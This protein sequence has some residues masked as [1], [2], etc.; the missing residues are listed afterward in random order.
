MSAKTTLHVALRVAAA[1]LLTLVLGACSVW[2]T[3][4]KVRSGQ[5]FSPGHEKYDAYFKEVHVLQLTAAGWDEEKRATRR[6]LVDAL[7]LDP[8]VADVSIVQAT[9]ER[10]V[11]IGREVGPARI[12]TKHKNDI[13]VAVAREHRVDAKAKELFRG[14]E[15]TVRA[16]LERAAAL[17]QVPDKIDSL[18]RT[19][20]ELLPLVRDDFA[21]RGGQLAMDVRDELE[22]SLDVLGTL[23]ASSRNAARE[24]E[25]F[26]ADL[27]RA[28]SADP[29]ERA[30]GAEPPNGDKPGKPSG[31]PAPPK[32]PPPPKTAEPPKP[33]PPPKSPPPPAPK[34]PPKP[35]PNADEVFNP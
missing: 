10:M 23:S 16:E 12:E 33:P 14:I 30:E 28:V 22:A 13:H 34:P 8:G 5:L 18:S 26:V 11:S 7:K 6:P 1:A 19:G 3:P 2:G 15:A 32:P 35:K 17:R 20:R 31:K 25:D 21:K 9:H 27:Q 4:S 24:A 29:S